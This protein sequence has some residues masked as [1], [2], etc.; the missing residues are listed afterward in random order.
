MLFMS[1]KLL[2]IVC[3]FREINFKLTNKININSYNNAFTLLL[4]IHLMIIDHY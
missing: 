4:L 3:T 2:K 1:A